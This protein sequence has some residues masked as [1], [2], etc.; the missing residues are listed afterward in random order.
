MR[1]SPGND[2]SSVRSSFRRWRQRRSQREPIPELL[3]QRALA[4]IESYPKAAICRELKLNPARFKQRLV[5]AAPS[6]PNARHAP[7]GFVEVCGSDLSSHARS[8]LPFSPVVGSS[9]CVRLVV[10]RPDGLR[11]SLELPAAE[12]SSLQALCSALLHS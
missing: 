5:T 11:L 10:E 1:N 7:A 3:W 8:N 2:L 6:H 12:H 9:S 4:L